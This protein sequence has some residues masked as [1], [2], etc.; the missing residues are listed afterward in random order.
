MSRLANRGANRG[1][2]RRAPERSSLGWREGEICGGV[3][4]GKGAS[5]KWCMGKSDMTVGMVNK[6]FL[7]FYGRIR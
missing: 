5:P 6:T 2:K 4:E 3:G 1:A 7:A